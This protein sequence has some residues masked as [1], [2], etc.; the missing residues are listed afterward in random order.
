MR[1]L[2]FFL[3][4]TPAAGEIRIHLCGH[5]NLRILR[6]IA[7]CAPRTSMSSSSAADLAG[8]PP[9]GGSGTR[10]GPSSPVRLT[11]THGHATSD[12]NMV[13]MMLPSGP[14]SFALGA[15]L[16]EEL[17]IG[18]RGPPLHAP[19]PH[20]DRS[21]AAS[22]AAS[23]ASESSAATTAG[24][25]SVTLFSSAA[26]GG[27]GG[28][29]GVG[30]G[31][32]ASAKAAKRAAAAATPEGPALTAVFKAA[33]RSAY[34]VDRLPRKLRPYYRMQNELCE[35]YVGVERTRERAEAE[36]ERARVEALVASE[37]ASSAMGTQGSGDVTAAANASSSIGRHGPASSVP[38]LGQPGGGA[39]PGLSLSLSS[40]GGSGLMGATDVSGASSSGAVTVHSPVPGDEEDEDG[41][42][43]KARAA[44]HKLA[45]AIAFAIN[46]SFVANIVLLGVSM[47]ETITAILWCCG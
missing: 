12:H 46:I 14:H 11:M 1:A 16:G 28:G 43:A 3:S 33:I 4:F 34:D 17:S 9:T 27:A 13:P 15:H 35:F 6:H 19:L 23:A 8:R 41:D 32:D 22:V 21:R 37:E 5:K 36:R 18:R 29:G 40:V 30:S 42:N 24:G 47:G 26:G 25:S 7:E 39:A 20:R 31:A 10:S 38:E 2:P 45:L 44:K